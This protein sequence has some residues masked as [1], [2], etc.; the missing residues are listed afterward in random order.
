MIYY[1]SQLNV[2]NSIEEEKNVQSHR[3][4]LKRKMFKTCSLSKHS[5]SQSLL[6]FKVIGDLIETSRKGHTLYLNKNCYNNLK[7]R[8]ISLQNTAKINRFVLL[9]FETIYSFRKC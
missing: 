1:S 6:C 9:N 7:I 2:P 4:L 5:D 3:M 8:K